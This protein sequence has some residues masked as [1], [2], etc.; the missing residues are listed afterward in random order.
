MYCMTYD[1]TDSMSWQV[2]P[3]TAWQ[4]QYIQIDRQQV[5]KFHL[6]KSTRIIKLTVNKVIPNHFYQ[7]MSY[8]NQARAEH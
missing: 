5:T 2:N 4:W 6:V 7:L 8:L 1:D 3:F